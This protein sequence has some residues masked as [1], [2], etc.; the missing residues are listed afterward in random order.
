MKKFFK[1]TVISILVLIII[2]ALIPFVF[3]GKILN[4]VKT[5]INKS[6]NA[7]VDFKDVDISLFRH[8]PK[9][10]VGLESLQVI[11]INEFA[12]D[13]LLSVKRLDV[14]LNLMSAIKGSDMKIYGISLDEPRIHVIVNKD[15][16]TN[17]D[18]VKPDTAAK[19]TAENKPFKME[20]EKYSIANGYVSYVD[21]V[22]NMSSTITNLNHEGSTF[23][24][25]IF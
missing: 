21:K 5:E 13:T 16:K 22:G 19:A 2:A 23:S 1:Y 8:F 20:L 9:L 10:A 14:S 17:W 4:M 3:K 11:G 12:E 15:G 18:I 24:K 7:K 6:I 25:I